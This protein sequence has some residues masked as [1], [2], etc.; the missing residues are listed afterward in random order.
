M[1][2]LTR[3][4]HDEDGA[5]IVLMV[6]VIVV[7]LGM[8]ALVVD[9]GALLDEKRQLQNGAD[10]GALAVA[11]SCRQL[12]SGPS[13]NDAL[14]TPLA[15]D[16]S[17]DGDSTAFVTHT[18]GYVTVQTRTGNGSS[19]VV[20][21]QFGRTLSGDKGKQIKATAVARWG[22]IKRTSVI[23]LTISRCE[24]DAA[25]VNNTVF[26]NPRVVLFKTTATKCINTNGTDLPGG[27]G[28][29]K[30]ADP[31]NDDCSVTPS[32]GGTVG[33]DTGLTGTPK[34]CNLASLLGKDVAL[35]IY[36]GTA[37]SGAGATYHIYG[38]ANFHLT[39]YQ[40]ASQSGGT[41]A[42]ASSES[43]IAGYFVKSIGSVGS[44][45]YGGPS[46]A[47]NLVTLIS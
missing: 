17:R 28:W 9:I 43:C 4:R 33:D 34:G 41:V 13:C 29:V 36:D 2:W 38:F 22:G 42:C 39:G 24:F 7:I 32:A 45:E 26:G 1:R 10:A 31:I 46:L 15:K 8:A 14:A 11:Q 5:V 19:D 44:G 47:G 37:G 18:P 30:D 40:F 3:P 12:P 16:N 35:V 20:P 25:T 27:F 6:V 21:F 23:P